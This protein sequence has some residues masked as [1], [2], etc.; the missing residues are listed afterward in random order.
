MKISNYLFSTILVAC[1]LLFHFPSLAG[2]VLNGNRVIFWG[3][4]SEKSLQFSTKDA[5]PYFVEVW[6]DDKL[7]T[8]GLV[9]TDA[10]FVVTPQVFRLAPNGRQP[11][12]LIFSHSKELPQDRE[13][14][15]YL[16]FLQAP[17]VKQNTRQKNNIF[18]RV[19]SKVKLFYRPEK[20]SAKAHSLGQKLQVS[21]DR[22]GA[23]PALKINNPTPY[24][25]TI[26]DVISVQEKGF[27]SPQQVLMIAPFSSDLVTLTAAQADQLRM[28]SFNLMYI[29]DYGRTVAAEFSL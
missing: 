16:N 7:E 27:F 17:A 9:A 15:F 24:Y 23:S 12:K 29:N 25:M 8:S 14:L 22:A 26:T 6:V 1:F 3:G 28:G 4:D 13:S 19:T 2:V 5:F 10:P 11:V 18:Y 21:L 20:L